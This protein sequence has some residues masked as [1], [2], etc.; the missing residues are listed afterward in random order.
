MKEHWF[1]R[2]HWSLTDAAPRRGL[3]R[4]AGPLA[5]A[6]LLGAAGS[7]QVDSK[8][9]KRGRNR[10]KG[11]TGGKG[12]KGKSK[13]NSPLASPDSCDIYWPGED[14]QEAQKAWCRRTRDE[15][16]PRDN[17]EFCIVEGDVDNPAR[18]AACCSSDESCC[19]DVYGLGDCASLLWDSS[20]CGRCGRGCDTGDYCAMANVSLA[21][22]PAARTVRECRLD[23]AKL[24]G[25][26]M[27][28]AAIRG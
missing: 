20:H 12:K 26:A 27:A 2:F 6:L 11:R 5:S 23:V 13:P 21:V 22:D 1:D 10:R 24:A 16:C 17:L 8:N 19:V 3:L 4:A 14:D 7:G 28:T 25:P 9:K 15:V 18:V